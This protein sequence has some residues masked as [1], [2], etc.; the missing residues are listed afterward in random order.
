MCEQC[1]RP[2]HLNWECGLVIE[3]EE[4]GDL[5]STGEPVWDF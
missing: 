2:S 3:L 5:S 4:P 1:V